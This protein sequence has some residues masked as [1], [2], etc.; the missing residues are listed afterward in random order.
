MLISK[1]I[2][3]EAETVLKELAERRNL[4]WNHG[5]I[6]DYQSFEALNKLFEII[7]S[8]IPREN[9][10]YKGDLYRIHTAYSSY[11]EDV[12]SEKERIIGEVCD[13]GSCSV[14]PVTEF[15]NTVVAFSKSPDFTRNVFYKVSPSHEAVIIHSNT[16][17]LFG[18]DVNKLFQRFGCRNIRLEEEMEVLFPITEETI[19]KEYCCTPLEFKALAEKTG[20]NN[21]EE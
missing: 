19:V 4:P 11:S 15:T 17:T 3:I 10:M 1:N 12:D 21:S 9:F 14:L 5:R 18:I 2:P 20:A 8:D 7:N 13:D 16:G 6:N